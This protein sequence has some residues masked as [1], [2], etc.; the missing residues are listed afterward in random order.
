[1][2]KAEDWLMEL[3][4]EV[5][6]QTESFG[7]NYMTCEIAYYV[8]I[9]KYGE[10]M[11]SELQQFGYR[12][13]EIKQKIV[14]RNVRKHKNTG[15]MLIDKKLQHVFMNAPAQEEFG[16]LLYLLTLHDN[17]PYFYLGLDSTEKE[18]R[19]VMQQKYGKLFQS[20][21]LLYE[22]KDKIEYC[23]DL[24]R[25]M[26]ETDQLFYGREKE[27][28]QMIMILLCKKKNNVMLLG[29]PGVGKTALVEAFAKKIVLGDVPKELQNSQVLMLNIAM[30]IGGTSGRGE[31]EE[32]VHNLLERLENSK[33]HIILFIDEFHSI[34]GLGNDGNFDL[35]NILKPILARSGLCCIGATTYREYQAYVEKDGALIRRF[36]TIQV[37]EPTVDE[38]YLMLQHVK[39]AYENY[40]HVY[41][42]N[43]A[44]KAC[45]EL[46]DSYIRNRRMPDKALDLLDESG[47]FAK[48]MM[49]NVV[50]K[51]I[52]IDLLSK[53]LQI[54]IFD[55]SIEAA[56]RLQQLDKGLQSIRG[57]KKAKK[58]LNHAL[59]FSELMKEDDEQSNYVIA[60]IGEKDF[61]KKRFIEE[62]R[63]TYFP[64]SEA[65]LEFDLSE[66]QEKHMLS[67]LIGAP[68]G[69]IGS[70]ES[71]ILVD[72]VKN[73]PR[74]LLVLKS[75]NSAHEKILEFLK[76][77]IQ[78]NCFTDVHGNEIQLQN[79]I[80]ILDYCGTQ[81]NSLDKIL[82]P[83]H[84]GIVEFENLTREE[85]RYCAQ[86][87]VQKICQKIK[88]YNI[89]LSLDNSALH[90]IDGICK[91]V[92]SEQELKEKIYLEISQCLSDVLMEYSDE[93]SSAV[94]YEE[95][96][97][98]KCR[99][100][101]KKI[102][103]K[104]L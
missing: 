64:V 16:E 22:N 60:F 98:L 93:K 103:G 78:S 25:K 17:L 74:I 42:Q 51:E 34:I 46:A 100:N 24:T 6:C 84:N 96:E 9:D 32:R 20:C 37:L 99:T 47:A 44:I 62:I 88:K 94:I 26:A 31:F 57:Y 5:K 86:D 19:Y 67:K 95:N 2:V 10:Y 21:S 54:P 79:S 77:I 61:G 38:S 87:A 50:T 68:P 80:V 83:L 45:V 43:E 104:V 41:Y 52:V 69:Y 89:Q 49:K 82:F 65:Y 81:G 27:I 30:L 102:G 72:K 55:K 85:L 33:N 66:Y 101:C 91:T 70:Q 12:P 90:W 14:L 92:E 4:N 63:K 36:Q 39:N 73:F 28:E 97:R 1:M 8:L 40:H 3:K 29:E 76:K 18:F 56:S 75:I 53:K 13:D 11:Q 71:G 58:M 35:A 59:L 23:T 7:K 15:E 48:R